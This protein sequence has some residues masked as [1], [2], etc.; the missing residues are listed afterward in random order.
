[1]FWNPQAETTEPTWGDC[2]YPRALLPN[3]SPRTAAQG[4]PPTPRNPKKPTLCRSRIDPAPRNQKR[5]AHCRSRIDPAPRNQKKPVHC[6]K[7]PTSKKTQNVCTHTRC[8]KS[9]CPE[10]SP[11]RRRWGMVTPPLACHHSIPRSGTGIGGA[12]P[13][14]PGQ[15]GCCADTAQSRNSGPLAAGPAG[16]VCLQPWRKHLPASS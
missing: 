1:M 6:N 16:R 3:R 13:A 10:R 12:S 2:L 14:S 4:W 15:V 11:E 8:R 5:P 9:R 7:D